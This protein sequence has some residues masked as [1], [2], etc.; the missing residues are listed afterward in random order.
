MEQQNEEPRAPDTQLSAS[1]DVG[2]AD[3]TRFRVDDGP[4]GRGLFATCDIPPRSLIHTAPCLLVGKEE[5]ANHGRHTILEHYLFNASGG[6]KLLAL[7]YG[8]LFNHSRHPNVDYR[9]DGTALTIRYMSGHKQIQA[10][11][12]LCISYGGNLWFDDAS[13]GHAADGR[14]SSSSDDADFLSRVEL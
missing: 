11:D 4:K 14:S 5:Y 6:D 13:E 8:S 1:D 12:E 2:C 3:D 7:G 9:V 10:G